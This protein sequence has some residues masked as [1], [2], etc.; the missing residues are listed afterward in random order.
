MY[1]YKFQIKRYETR[2]IKWRQAITSQHIHQR[3]N[4]N[5]KIGWFQFSSYAYITYIF[6]IIIDIKN[7][8]C[9][10]NFADSASLLHKNKT[11]KDIY[12][13]KPVLRDHGEQKSG[14]LRRMSFS[15]GSIYYEIYHRGSRIGGILT[16]VFA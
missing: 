11:N 3:T 14:L 10:K 4:P 8:K 6:V 16:H 12:T 2:N 15:T 1:Q 7:K 5:S 13:V 9:V